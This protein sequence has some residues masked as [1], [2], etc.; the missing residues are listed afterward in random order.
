LL[1]TFSIAQVRTVKALQESPHGFASWRWRESMVMETLR[2]LPDDVEI[3]TNQPTAVYFWIDRPVYRL[4]DAQ[5]KSLQSGEAA[6]AIFFPP[7]DESPEF[8]AWFAEM[9]EGLTLVEKSG[10]GNLYTK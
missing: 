4:W 10:L 5:P 6:M 8:Q 3:H 9:T 2:N 7:D 1:V